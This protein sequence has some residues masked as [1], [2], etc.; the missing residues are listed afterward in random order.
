MLNPV[1]IIESIEK[2]RKMKN[3]FLISEFAKLRGININSLRYYEKLGI[4]KP[5]YVDQQTGYRYYSPEQ[6]PLLNQIILC[7]QLGIPLKEMTVF[8]DESGNLQSRKLLEKGK[9]VAQQRIKE[10]EDN[11]R[12]IETSLSDMEN[13]A[14]F[15]EV[16]GRYSRYIEERKIIVTDYCEENPNVK[17][18]AS[19]VSELYKTAQK[20]GL[21]PLLPAG[22]ILEIDPSGNIRIRFFLKVL[23]TN[24]DHPLIKILPA[25]TYSCVQMSL[26]TDFEL[27]NPAATKNKFLEL[28]GQIGDTNTPYTLIIDNITL[29]KYSFLN[30]P[31]ELQRLDYERNHL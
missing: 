3:Y 29:E 5:A 27:T 24:K 1:I 13:N 25:G 31:S 30:S 2:R 4:L 17:E 28:I 14:A 8:L 19:L 16:D 9:L 21:F 18:I 23:T 20:D 10:L 12:Y 15:T 7:I 22:Q 11:L 26:P 6:L